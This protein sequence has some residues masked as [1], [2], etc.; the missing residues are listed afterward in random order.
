M[1]EFKSL[2]EQLYIKVG[3]P[4]PDKSPLN[5]RNV[6]IYAKEKGLISQEQFSQIEAIFY[7]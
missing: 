4:T 5:I 6:V 7:S 2:L 1:N 3:Y